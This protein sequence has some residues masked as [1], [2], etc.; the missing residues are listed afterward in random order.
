MQCCLI[1][2]RDQ[3]I[4]L[5]CFLFRVRLHWTLT[6][7]QHLAI[8]ESVGCR[9]LCWSQVNLRKH[10]HGILCFFATK[11]QATTNARPAL[12]QHCS[13]SSRCLGAVCHNSAHHLT[14]MADTNPLAR[15]GKVAMGTVGK[16]RNASSALQLDCAIRDD[17]PSEECTGLTRGQIGRT[18]L[19]ASVKLPLSQW[20]LAFG[21]KGNGKQG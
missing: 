8:T 13:R 4:C 20:W 5:F 2:V 12:V 7:V 18:D 1:P 3:P 19:L 16:G 15:P 11:C 14:R 9:H 10:W 21:V 6:R 17:R